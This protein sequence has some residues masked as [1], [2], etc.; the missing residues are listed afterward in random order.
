MKVILQKDV[1]NLG[2]AGEIKEVASG[3]AR[4]YLLPRKLVIPAHAGSQRALAHHKRIMEQKAAKRNAEM[5]KVSENLAGVKSLEIT[6]RVGA[7]NRM[8]GSVTTAQIAALLAEK[9]FPLDKR[10]VELGEKIRTLGNYQIKIRLA[11]KIL[12]P[13][14]LSVVADAESQAAAEEEAAEVAAMEARAKAQQAAQ[15]AAER[16][17]TPEAAA[18]EGEEGAADEAG[19][20]AEPEA[21]GEENAAE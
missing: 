6:V 4:N 19:Q 5:A 10:K 1:A 17:E 9:G 20:S 16:G 2:D 18:E 13:L 12:V 3:Y 7:N 15:E 8:F 14:E 21:A 11:E